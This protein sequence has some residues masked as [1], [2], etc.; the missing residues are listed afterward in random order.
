MSLPFL[1]VTRAEIEKLGWD[2]VDVVLVTGD[3]YVDHPSFG[4]AVVGRVLEAE[5]FRVAVISMPDW[6][7]PSSVMTFGRPRLFFGVTSGNVDSMLARWTS[8]GKARR[9]DPYVPGGKAG[10]RPERAVIVFCNLIRAAYRDIPVVIGGIEASMRRLAHYDYR[11]DRVRRSLLED[12]RADL[13]VYGMGEHQVAEAARRLARGESLS[14]IAGTVE[15]TR[16]APSGALELPSEERA[17]SDKKDFAEFFRLF[18]LNQDRVLVQP[19]AKRFL[20]Q[21]PSPRMESE[22]L[23]RIHDLP[24]SRRPHPSYTEEVPA[25]AMIRNSVASHRGCVSGC[26]FCSLSLH[27]G[28]RIVSRSERSVL[29]EVDQLAGMEYFKG[30]VNDIGGPSANMYGCSCGRDWRCSRDSCTNPD[31]CPNLRVSTKRWIG[32]LGKAAKRGGVKLVTVGSGIRYDLLM[33]DDPSLLRDL[34]AHHVSG[35]LKIAPEHTSER[36]LAV[37]RKKPLA[38]LKD[39]TGAFFRE[40]RAL[41]KRLYIIPYLMSCHPGCTLKDMHEAKR[42]A[43]SVFSFLPEQ[44]QAFIPLPMTLSSVIY[45]TGVDPLTGEKVFVERDPAGRRRQHRVLLPGKK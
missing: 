38:D 16:N 40:S 20:V 1:P 32:L 17:V 15:I 23:D 36:V 13:L 19:A 3:A 2:C 18:Y 34:I 30:H 28:R 37:M 45:H 31:L 29:A 8:F 11:E 12:A 21:Y 4:S 9:D 24:F 6:K 44:V 14:G 10:R 26:A 27:Q 41:G 43:L 22:D 7:D 5:G 35:Q 33:R 42:E 25:F 39:F